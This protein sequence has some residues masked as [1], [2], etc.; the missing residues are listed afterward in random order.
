MLPRIQ[1]L[2][3]VVICFMFVLH[4]IS[5]NVLHV[6]SHRHND[7]YTNNTVTSYPPNI[8][9]TSTPAALSGTNVKDAR[10][11]KDARDARDVRDVHLRSYSH[12]NTS[13]VQDDLAI[14]DETASTDDF[15]TYKMALLFAYAPPSVTYDE[16][17]APSGNVL[18]YPEFLKHPFSSPGHHPAYVPLDKTLRQVL[19]WPGGFF[20]ESGGHDGSF[21]SNTLALEKLF[22][23]R[24]ILVE[25]AAS[26][27]PK[28]H[29]TRP[30]SIVFHNGLVS[31][32]DDGKL[33][34]DPG[35][36]PMGKISV[37]KGAVTGRALSSLLDE[38]NITRIDFWSLDV[39]GH[40]VEVLKGVDFKRHRPKYVVI[41]VRTYNKARVFE[42][43]S[44]VSYNLVSGYDVE[45]G[46]SG[47]PANIEHRDFLWRDSHM[48][49]IVPLIMK[50]V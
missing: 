27:I 42:L 4:F 30:R 16:W 2:I 5:F 8:S 50:P 38:L 9:L 28:I 26:N 14:H 25:P 45:Q 35:G 48:A 1:F 49:G 20:I 11:T 18:S 39:E 23:W 19:T 46:I 47:F 34:S 41:E 10:D 12:T 3:L 29:K 13:A 24:G 6:H 31:F 37:G 17:S 40:E 36:S 32:K 43:M 22:G 7:S 44:S 33:I 21:Q 15:L